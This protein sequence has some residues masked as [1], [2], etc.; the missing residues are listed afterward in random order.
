MFAVHGRLETVRYDEVIVPTDRRF[1]VGSTW[2]G[3]LSGVR[4]VR[5]DNW[6][7][8]YGRSQEN[9]GVWFISVF[10]DVAV[11]GDEL[12]QRLDVLVGAIVAESRLSSVDRRVVA[13][14]VL[15]LGGGAQGARRGEVIRELVA[16]LSRIASQH[17]VDIALVTPDLAVHGAIQ[18]LRR[19]HSETH[20][21]L[22]R[23]EAD[24]AAELGA[25]AQQGHLALFL[26]A[27]VSMAAGLPSWGQLLRDLSRHAKIA[28]SDFDSLA[29]SPLDQAELISLHLNDRLGSTVAAIVR[30]KT[31][32][33][34]AHAL[35]AGLDCGEVVTTNYDG[36]YEL[37]VESTGR[38]RPVQLPRE[39]VRAGRPW[40]LKMH[41]DVSDEDSIVLTR[42]SFVRYD[43][44]SRPAGS[45][46]QSLMMTKHLLVVGTSMSDDNVI[47]LAVEVDDFLK[48]D[49]HFGTF[50]D[51]SAPSAR[52]K[53]WEKRFHWLNCAGDD[54]AARVR[55]MEIF[56]DAVGM[57]AATDASWLLDGRFAG[58]LEPTDRKIT[59]EA[60]R[61]AQKAFE[62]GSGLLQP[63]QQRL[64]ELGAKRQT[65]LP[66]LSRTRATLQ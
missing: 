7:R 65:K 2:D 63:L 14:P 48:S 32:V 29:D 43:A 16:A 39:T 62:S 9:A 13:L 4:P 20:F 3:V 15:G 52:T 37:A 45:L 60:R 6:G 51:V 38:P 40:L 46:L 33:S 44:Q 28:S 42:R 5:P 53:L 61:V 47:R 24:A 41:G 21:E 11:T 58:L 27:G 34:L 25:L 30:A 66:R 31:Q 59:A 17:G 54:T 23:T 8:G 36:L 19:Q 22:S 26:G 10:D 1:R 56:L 55:R 35:L 64:G 49:A 57:F 18:H 12:E 50:V